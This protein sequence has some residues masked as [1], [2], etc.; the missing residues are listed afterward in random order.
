MTVSFAF[1]SSVIH[2]NNYRWR[3]DNGDINTAT[4]KAAENTDVNVEK[5]ENIRLRIE[6][7]NETATPDD[8]APGIKLRYSHNGVETI[9]SNDINNAFVLSESPFFAEMDNINDL[10]TNTNAFVHGGGY[11]IESSL[12]KDFTFDYEKS[13]EVEYCIK[14]TPNAVVGDSYNFTFEENGTAL[15]IDNA[16]PMLTIIS[17]QPPLSVPLETSAIALAFLLVAGFTKLRF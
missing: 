14:A 5:N 12:S 4:F 6:F 17:T 2:Q 13:Y 10:L 3:N 15:E 11:T 1:A 7:Y 9:I 8:Y 16:E